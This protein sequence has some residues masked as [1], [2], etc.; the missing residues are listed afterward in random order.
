MATILVIV[1]YLSIVLAAQV[2]LTH[3]TARLVGATGATWKRAAAVVAVLTGWALLWIPFLQ[4]VETFDNDRMFTIALPLYAVI[5]VTIFLIYRR[6][7]RLRPKQLLGFVVMHVVLIACTYAVLLPAKW[8]VFEAF[9]I[10]T[11]S[12]APTVVGRRI[13]T[14][15]GYCGSLVVTTVDEDPLAPF[16]PGACTR[17]GK[18]AEHID[19]HGEKLSGDRLIVAKWYEPRRWDIVAFQHP[20]EPATIYLKRIVGLP[21]EE[22]VIGDDGVLIV[23]GKRLEPPAMLADLRYT[24][25]ADDPSTRANDG[26]PLWGD[27]RRPIKLNF[28]EY[29]LLGDHTYRALDARFWGPVKREA[30]VGTMTLIYWP[31]SRWRIFK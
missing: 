14:M 7:Y 9:K 29:Y 24:L 22:I 31:P 18:E 4:A 10:P 17:C 19:V 6:A 27:P 8:Y 25:F 3:G 15:C 23:D 2:G 28:D 16:D 20:T 5:L 21:D 1:A 30:I 11:N 13:E 12:M 26:D